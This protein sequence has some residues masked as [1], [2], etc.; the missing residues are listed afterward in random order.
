MS[1]PGSPDISL[2]FFSLYEASKAILGICSEFKRLVESKRR[3][4][5]SFPIY[6]P[7][8]ALRRT[9]RQIIYD[10]GGNTAN[11]Y[12]GA[13]KDLDDIFLFIY[14]V[15]TSKKSIN[16][17]PRL[18]TILNK[19]P[20]SDIRCGIFPSTSKDLSQGLP[21]NCLFQLLFCLYQHGCPAVEGGTMSIASG[22][23]K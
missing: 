1:D 3:W 21:S 22:F 19:D 14:K 2:H 23:C 20:P 11:Y 10:R 18:L 16:E 6:P 9:S 7:A 8:R 5:L 15:D 4:K 13:K 12:Y 17:T